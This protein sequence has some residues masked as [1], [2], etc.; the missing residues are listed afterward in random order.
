M[1]SSLRINI[2]R[3]FIYLSCL[4][5]TIIAYK[6][7]QF[8]SEFYVFEY[9]FPFYKSEL[10]KGLILDNLMILYWLLVALLFVGFIKGT[11]SRLYTVSLYL[12]F[13]SLEKAI[14]PVLDGG[15]NFT[16]LVIFFLILINEKK[17]RSSALSKVF[18]FL[19]ISQLCLVYFF[20]VI[21]KFQNP[22][23]LNGTAIFYV[24]TSYQYS[25]NWVSEFV[26]TINPAILVIPTYFIL[27]FQFTYPLG[28]T[29]Q[30]L[31]RY[32]IIVGIFFHLFIGIIMGLPSFA[33]HFISAYSIF[34]NYNAIK[35][36]LRKKAN[37]KTYI[38]KPLNLFKDKFTIFTSFLS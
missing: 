30:N 23:W 27:F 10:L 11:A 9:R 20:S 2:F 18:K 28:V 19:I 32:Y 7:Y 13:I 3:R 33:V 14:W 1:I 6:V 38:R 35:W 36:I 5:H 25:T 12:I 26:R 22:I 34:L 4:I 21:S 15:N 37:T 24:L 29:N 8:Q 17:C 31:K 16:H